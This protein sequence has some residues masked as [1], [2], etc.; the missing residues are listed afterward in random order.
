MF[1]E[2]ADVLRLWLDRAFPY[3][4]VESS[5]PHGEDTLSVS[6]IVIT[7]VL[8]GAAE[9][10]GQVAVDAI[11]TKIADLVERYQARHGSL[12]QAD[13]KETADATANATVAANAAANVS[14]NAAATADTASSPHIPPDGTD[15]EAS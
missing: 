10:A 13:L 14:A 9:A 4:W 1:R 8:T 2:D 12:A 11:R 5:A 3:D 15:R 7:A 6:D